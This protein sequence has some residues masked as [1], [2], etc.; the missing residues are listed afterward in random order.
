MQTCVHA[1]AAGLPCDWAA[2]PKNKKTRLLQTYPRK[3][4]RWRLML[5]RLFCS[6]SISRIQPAKH[7]GSQGCS[8]P[9]QTSLPRRKQRQNTKAR[10]GVPSAG[11]QAHQE[12]NSSGKHSAAPRPTRVFQQPMEEQEG[13]G[14]ARVFWQCTHS[15]RTVHA[16]CTPQCTRSKWCK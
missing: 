14:R 11:T 3:V 10:K 9:G 8:N 13:A 7:Q 5:Q 1:H 16:Q 6:I 2:K 15:A 12:A 4:C